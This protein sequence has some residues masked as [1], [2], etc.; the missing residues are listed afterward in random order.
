M[1]TTEQAEVKGRIEGRAGE[2]LTP[3]ALSFLGRL[4]REFGGRRQD[5]LRKRDER[6]AL[7][8]AG[9]MPQF[10]PSTAQIRD[11]EWTVAKA[12][13]DLQD[14]RVEIT[15]PTDRKMVI[16]ALNSGARV[17]M[18]DFEDANSPTWSNLVEGQVNLIDAIER[19]I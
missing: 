18:A 19:R 10:L 4:Q 17:F 5:L 11:A 8:D 16:N 7:L 6:Q 1:A 3:D 2:V 9:E 13:T 15:G 14:R 12:P